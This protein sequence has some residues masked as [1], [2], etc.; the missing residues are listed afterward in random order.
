MKRSIL[1]TA[2]LTVF[3][4]CW[5]QL[6]TTNNA[7]SKVFKVFLTKGTEP[8]LFNAGDVAAKFDFDSIGKN[9][10]SVFPEAVREAKM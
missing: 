6:P 1:I 9:A 7:T 3:I 10:A 5:A 4:S 2:L 8:V